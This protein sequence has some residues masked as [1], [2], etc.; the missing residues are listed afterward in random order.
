MLISLHFFFYLYDWKINYFFKE[1]L[2]VPNSFSPQSFHTETLKGETHFRWFNHKGKNGKVSDCCKREILLIG[3]GVFLRDELTGSSRK[4]N[5][6][7]RT[8]GNKKQNKQKQTNMQ[9]ERSKPRCDMCQKQLRTFAA[10]EC[11]AACV[12]HVARPPENVS[13]H[14]AVFLV[15][16]L[17]GPGGCLRT[18]ASKALTELFISAL[19]L[20]VLLAVSTS[21]D[22]A[23]SQHQV[24]I[25]NLEEL[26]TRWEKQVCKICLG[27][28]RANNWHDLKRNIKTNKHIAQYKLKKKIVTLISKQTMF[29]RYINALQLETT[30]VPYWVGT[31]A[32]LLAFTVKNIEGT[33][34]SSNG[35]DNKGGRV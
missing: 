1:S 12:A 10:E 5:L 20:L 9:T 22:S 32:A 27:V 17:A 11:G 14:K 24:F 18:Q 31:S 6:S 34:K 4:N 25:W 23:T 28:V 3:D 8:F 2:C 26:K 13:K 19:S 7:W 16:G 35:Y 15:P 29:I 33:L 30:E 21:L